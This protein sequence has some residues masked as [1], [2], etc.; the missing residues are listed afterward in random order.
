MNDR[1]IGFW[2][3]QVPGWILLLYLIV[4]QGIPAF[5]YQLGVRMG[6]QESAAAVTEVGAAFWYGFAFGDLITYIPLLAVGLFGYWF[7]YTWSRA[8]L[9]AAL[10]IT[11]YWPVVC[12]TTVSAAHGLEGWSLANETAYWF[13]LPIIALWGAFSL[14]RI[15][16]ETKRRFE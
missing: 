9:A 7:G 12:L 8:V 5:D 3:I 13:V 6:T 15:S 2:V 1:S 4:A 11:V 14:W 10:G 16:I